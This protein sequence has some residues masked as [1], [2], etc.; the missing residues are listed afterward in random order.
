METKHILALMLFTAFGCGAILAT[1]FSRRLRDLAFICMVVFSIYAERF[2]VNFFGQY[3][4]RGTSRGVGISI[5]DVLAW[6]ILI[7]SL[8][9][10]KYVRRPGFVPAGLFVIGL[11]FLYCV[12]MTFNALV[13]L[14]AVW[15]LANI[16]RGVLVMLAGAAYIR[17]RRELGFLV[18][19]LALTA[20]VEALYGFKQRY[21]DGMYRVAG[22][23]DHSNSLSM[24][25]CTIGPVLAAGFMSNWSKWVRIAAG[26][27]ALAATGG[28]LLTIS[29]AGLPIYAM[30]MLGT[31]VMSTSFKVTLKKVVI[32]TSLLA[33]SVIVLAKMW[34]QIA[35]RYAEA[36]FA[37]EY[38][39]KENEG[40]GVYIRWAQ[41]ILD[42]H[43]Y[44]VGLNN[45][46]YAVSKTYGPES[47]FRYEDYDDIKGNPE[48][49]DLPS[50]NYAA[51]AHSLAALT[52]GE[53]GLPG[54][55][56][57]GL[58]WARLFFMGAGF[59]IKRLNDD[60]MH[61]M[62]IGFFFAI[63]G[64]FLQSVTEWVYRGSTIFLMF[65]LLM[66]ALASLQWTRLHPYPTAPDPKDLD[67]VEENE[68]EVE[69]RPLE[70]S[71]TYVSR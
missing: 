51:P 29:R 43:R 58:V 10:P 11:Y 22:T 36:S 60:P 5:T 48:K 49:A 57:F 69:A 25:L 12:Y 41:A 71:T 18:V 24:Y 1:T 16:P 17:S 52:A 59:L 32:C 56:L 50:I 66:G 55:A 23:L 26:I 47:G 70:V 42:D 38:L 2:D 27:G 31:V 30:V 19:A 35:S 40:R 64:I 45:W 61:R 53:L 13:P 15:E 21:A 37:E 34:D 65:H 28:V 44:G 8:I 68:T 33:V 14:Y 62:G 39:D 63:C 67:V 7:S 6:A 4:Y 46:S 54:L 20:C 3:W 9:T